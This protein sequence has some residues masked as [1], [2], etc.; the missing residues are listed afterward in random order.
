MTLEELKARV[1][2]HQIHR[3]LGW[4]REAHWET[5]SRRHEIP[6]TRWTVYPQFHPLRVERNHHGFFVCR[7]EQYQYDTY[8][9]VL[10]RTFLVLT[11]DSAVETAVFV[12]GERSF[13]M[14]RHLDITGVEVTGSVQRHFIITHNDLA[15]SFN[16]IAPL[17]PL[18]PFDADPV[19]G[20]R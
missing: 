5:E 11:D 16:A 12:T 9:G 19:Y 6:G 2:A 15:I 18:I 4:P 3:P 7:E 14:P 8:K 13:F 1:R 20:R 10:R 17:K